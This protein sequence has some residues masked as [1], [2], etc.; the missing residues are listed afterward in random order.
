M[1][2]MLLFRSLCSW[3]MFVLDLCLNHGAQRNHDH[4][5]GSSA[6]VLARN[7]FMACVARNFV[8]HIG[9]VTSGCA[10]KVMVRQ[11]EPLHAIKAF[12]FQP[13]FATRCRFALMGNSQQR[14]VLPADE[15]FFFIPRDFLLDPRLAY[16]PS[17]RDATEHVR[18]GRYRAGHR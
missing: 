6:G 9:C 4:H 3:V 2:S 11:S 18:C 8:Q 10:R 13:C 1:Y 5:S 7:P 17:S 15:R 12:C 14:T 16:I